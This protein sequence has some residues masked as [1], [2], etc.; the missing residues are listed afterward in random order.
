V[1]LSWQV[2]S[3]AIATVQMSSAALKAELDEVGVPVAAAVSATVWTVLVV[4]SELDVN[5]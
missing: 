1:T 4:F 5:L 2:D 3:T